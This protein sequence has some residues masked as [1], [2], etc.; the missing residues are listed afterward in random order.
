M[1]DLKSSKIK[2]PKHFY[3]FWI[4]I[5]INFTVRILQS[6]YL[7]IMSISF[8]GNIRIEKVNV[9]KVEIGTVDNVSAE[10]THG[11]TT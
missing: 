10:N 2:R 4:P 6:D 11:F 5:F 1:L 9:W 7:I 3:W 8:A